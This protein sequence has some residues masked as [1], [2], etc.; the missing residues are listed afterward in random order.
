MVPEIS[1]HDYDRFHYV[2]YSGLQHDLLNYNSVLV[3]R[4]STVAYDT[5][6]SVIL[7]NCLGYEGPLRGG[8]LSFNLEKVVAYT[9]T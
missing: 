7:R 4:I 3:R 9:C 5:Q 2:T 8:L 6:G 1:C